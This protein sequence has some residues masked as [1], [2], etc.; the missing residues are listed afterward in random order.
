L[1]ALTGDKGESITV[2]QG[3]ISVSNKA[4]VGYLEQKGVSGSTKTVREE[5]VSRMDRLQQATKQ[6]EA[7][8]QA[9]CDGDTS[10]AALSA[11]EDANAEF[12]LA[13]GFTV[14]KRVANVLEGL[15]FSEEDYE[16]RCSEF[17]GGWQMRIALAR[18]LLCAPDLLILDEP[19]NHLDQRAKDWLGKY[20]AAFDGTLLVVSHD[21]A[22]L[23]AATTS[24]AEVREGAIDLFKSRS[25]DQWQVERVERVRAQQALYEAKQREIARLQVFVDRFGAKTMG[26][27]MAQSRLKTIE[28]I[29]ASLPDRVSPLPMP[30]ATPSASASTSTSTSTSSASVLQLPAPPRG[31]GEELLALRGASL[32]WPLQLLPPLPYLQPQTPGDRD[33]ASVTRGDRGDSVAMG[34]VPSSSASVSASANIDRSSD[35]GALTITSTAATAAVANEPFIIKD[36]NLVIQR[37]MRIAVRGPNGAGKSTLLSALSGA[38]APAAGSRIESDGLALGVFTQDLAQDLDQAARAVDLVTAAGRR[39]DSGL[40]DQRARAVLGALG[41]RGEKA[42]RPVGSLSGGE[43]AR[44]ALASFVVR[45]HNLLLLDEPTNHLDSGTIRVLTEALREFGGDTSSTGGG[46]GGGGRRGVGGGGGAMFVIS[47]DRRF[48]ES[49]DPT[50]VVTV[51]AGKVVMEQRG[52]Q[53]RDWLYDD[54]MARTTE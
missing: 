39:H 19:S 23:A 6:L 21:S 30:A 15:G 26:A 54:G 10:E 29:A 7:A 4:R 25:H 20:L 28:K 9:V 2:R 41:L 35:R 22:L 5:V 18:L 53:A 34:G 50:H 45:P 47:H 51:G 12:E 42:L 40:S 14:E 11:L 32:S 1:R 36:C 43:K 38:L 33:E 27:S 16:K 52:L 48:L 37:G 31:G 8:E 17:S 44:V 3:S 46:G 24:I 13:G 49:L